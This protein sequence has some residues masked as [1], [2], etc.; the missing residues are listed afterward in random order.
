MRSAEGSG[1]KWK[2]TVMTEVVEWDEEIVEVEGET[3]E[4]VVA[5]VNEEYPDADHFYV[6]GT[7]YQ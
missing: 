4:E 7:L 2:V 6:G 3:E 5:K 1:M